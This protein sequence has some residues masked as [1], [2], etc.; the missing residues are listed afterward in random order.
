MTVG[1]GRTALD[2]REALLETAFGRAKAQSD[3]Q[4]YHAAV[5]Q[6]ERIEVEAEALDGTAT[7]QEGPLPDS[8]LYITLDGLFVILYRRDGEEVDIERVLPSR[9]NWKPGS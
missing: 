8:R 6:D 2:D 9:S 5:A 7:W 1:W 3:P 4:L